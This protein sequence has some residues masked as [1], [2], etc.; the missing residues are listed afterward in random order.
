MRIVSSGEFG[1]QQSLQ[2]G[3]F[4]DEWTIEE[5]AG[6]AVDSQDRVY[7]LTRKRNGVIVFDQEGRHLMTWGE[8]L[9]EIP[10]GLFIS[11]DDSVYCV[12]HVAHTVHKLTTDGQ[13]LMTMSNTDSPSAPNG[14]QHHSPE[15]PVWIAGPPFNL[16]TWL[17]VAPQGDMYVTDGYGN[18][19][20]HKYTPD[21][22][23]LLSWG[24]PGTGDGQFN[25]PHGACVDADGKVYVADRQNCR[26]QIFSPN[27][28]YIDEW[29]DANYPCDMC[30]DSNQNMY[31]AELGGFFMGDE[32]PDLTMPI[33]RVTVRNLQGEI[34]AEWTDEDI[35]GTGRYFAPHSIAIDSNGDL[36]LGQVSKSYTEGT[37]PADWN[38][39]RKYIRA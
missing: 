36:Y 24:E 20:V 9:F 38:T 3:Q 14:S 37:A 34:L 2:W 21:G 10:H 7:M 29:D 30:L 22:K 1:Y 16:P 8:D 19:Q 39:L 6:V 26:I 35:L 12:D 27:G 13:L 17:T 32:K 28:D 23:L 15:D 11:T 5:I 4:P 33:P 18:S 25:V 31:V